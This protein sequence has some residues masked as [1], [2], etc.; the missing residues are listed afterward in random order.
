MVG[1]HGGHV[2]IKAIPTQVSLLAEASIMSTK[3]FTVIAKMSERESRAGLAQEAILLLLLLTESSTHGGSI[4]INLH[5]HSTT[6]VLL[7]GLRQRKGHVLG[8]AVPPD[9]CGEVLY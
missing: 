8:E 7:H 4:C 6:E 9:V 2:R 5:P 3:I 1:H